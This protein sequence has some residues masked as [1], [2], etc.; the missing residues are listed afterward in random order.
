[1]QYK[2]IYTHWGTEFTDISDLL[3]QDVRELRKILY[4]RKMLVFHAPDWDQLTYWKF[5]ALWG[6]PWDREEYIKSTERWREVPDPESGQM[7]YITWMSNK[8]SKRL[9]D[10]KMP[11]HAD[12]ANRV[13]GINF[14]HRC[15]YMK[16]V[17]NPEAG[18]TYWLDMEE[19]YYHVHPIL[20]KRWESRTILQQNWHHP[21]RDVVETSAMKQHPIT[22]KWSPRCNYHGIKNSWILD[23]K[24]S[25]GNSRGTGIL[26]ELMEAMSEVKDCVYEMRWQPNDIVL[27]DNWPFVHRRT[28][29]NLKEGEERLMWRANI[30]HDVDL[31]IE[32]INA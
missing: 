18:F 16:T 17:P 19:A 20:R 10:Y 29:P 7:R 30:D 32:F 15:I 14:P 23:T 11:W 8:L 31:T 6:N 12:I 2:D 22:G 27:Y 26:E 25:L 1:M 5:L 24:D 28:A 21:G 3:Q 4:Q 13:A 9:V